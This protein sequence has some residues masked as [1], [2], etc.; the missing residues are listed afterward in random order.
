MRYFA[1][2]LELEQPF[3][4]K[5]TSDSLC[6]RA[7]IIQVGFVVFEIEPEFKIIDSYCKCINIFNN[8]PSRN[9]TLALVDEPLISKF[10][11]KLT[12]ISTENVL[13]GTS[14]EATYLTMTSMIE[15]YNVSRIVRQWGSGDMEE[16]RAD[17]PNVTWQFGGGGYNVKHLHQTLSEVHGKDSRGGLGKAL[18]TWGLQWQSLPGR[19]QKESKK[20]NALSDALN[21]AYLYHHLVELI[22]KG[23]VL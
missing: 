20:H 14:L 13:N 8:L 21:T 18:K 7:E 1:L 3:T 9:I 11:Q 10:I 16:Y 12:G 19:S 15:K 22:K 5:D 2:D 17:L 4:R 23:V 6:D